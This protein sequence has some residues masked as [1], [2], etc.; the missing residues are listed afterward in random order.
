MLMIILNG[1]YLK[2]TGKMLFFLLTAIGSF[3]LIE[4]ACSILTS[5][6]E[7]VL[8]YYILLFSDIHVI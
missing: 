6:A 7:A 4:N 1:R 8:K 2:N 5:K 3:F